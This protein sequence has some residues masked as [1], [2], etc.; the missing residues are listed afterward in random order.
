[1][2]VG[3]ATKESSKIISYGPVTGVSSKAKIET[4]TGKDLSVKPYRVGD[5]ISDNVTGQQ[6][7]FEVESID[8]EPTIKP[9]SGTLV[10]S[11]TTNITTST[12]PK[13]VSFQF[14][15]TLGSY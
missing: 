2:S 14:V 3:A 1:M 10:S 5:V 8:A 13:E 11:N 12:A 4:I 7:R 9:F 6:F 15:Y